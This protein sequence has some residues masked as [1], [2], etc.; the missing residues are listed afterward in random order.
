[1]SVLF[2]LSPRGLIL[3]GVLTLGLTSGGAVWG[4]DATKTEPSPVA[5]GTLSRP[6]FD[7]TKPVYDP[8][9]GIDNAANT[10]IAEI[11]GHP[12][13]LGDIGDAIR[14]LPPNMAGLPFEALYP[15]ILEQLV[16]QESM[17]MR[18]QSQGLDEDPVVRRRV[19]AAANGVIANEYLRRVGEKGIT[20]AAMLD[21]YKRDVASKAGPGEVRARMIAVPTQKEAEDLIAELR[22]GADFAT[23]ARRASKDVT[24]ANGGDIGFSTRDALNAEAGA[25]IFALDVGQITAHPVRSGTSWLVL[26][27]EERRKGEVPGYYTVREAVRNAILQEAVT[28]LVTAAPDG[29]K[30]RQFDFMGQEI[31]EAPQRVERGQEDTK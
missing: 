7:T 27:V 14:A 19:R 26:R 22:G 28:R 31:G 10:V 16:R 13:T 6:V 1:M 21:R 30:L 15:G 25:V 3:M 5:P 17:V 23:L 24:A 2:G 29:F 12:I 9:S 11:E 20:E 8:A 18:A 4:Q